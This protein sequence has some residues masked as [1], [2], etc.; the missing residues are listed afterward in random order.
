MSALCNK[1]ITTNINQ[2]TI[3]IISYSALPRLLPPSIYCFCPDVLLYLGNIFILLCFVHHTQISLTLTSNTP[4][5]PAITETYNL[6]LKSAF[7]LI[8]I[9]FIQRKI[10][11]ILYLIMYMHALYSS[12]PIPKIPAL[13]GSYTVSYKQPGTSEQFS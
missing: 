9:I 10:I 1:E 12:P 11:Y 7:Y 6:N 3:Q 13:K 4:P 2:C 5:P 8:S